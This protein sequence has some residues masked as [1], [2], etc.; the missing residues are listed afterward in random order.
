MLLKNLMA[1]WPP[2]TIATVAWLEKQGISRFL[3][4]QYIKSGWIKSLGYG[5]VVRSH[6]QAGWPGALWALQ[7]Q[8]ELPI[9]IGGKS[10]IALLG[11]SHYLHFGKER[12]TLFTPRGTHPPRWFREGA[13]SVNLEIIKTNFL[14]PALGLLAHSVEGVEVRVSSLERAILEL[15]YLVPRRASWGEIRLIFENLTTL[16]PHVAQGLLMRCRNYRVT[17]LFLYLAETHQ[18]PWF[19]MLDL[20]LIPQGSGVLQLSKGGLYVPKYRMTIP[21]EFNNKGDDDERSLF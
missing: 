15:L 19:R 21:K 11:R 10:A 14:D 18:H 17:R 2:H 13:W 3:K 5:A 9:H 16:Q 1:A 8:A 7:T 6:E 20:K 12:L 4:R